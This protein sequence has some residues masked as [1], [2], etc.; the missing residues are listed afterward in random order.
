MQN[1]HQLVYSRRKT[2]KTWNLTFLTPYRR[3][4]TKNAI[5]AFNFYNFE[6]LFPFKSIFPLIFYFHPG[7]GRSGFNYKLFSNNRV[8][9]DNFSS[10]VNIFRDFLLIIFSRFSSV[11]L[12]YLLPIK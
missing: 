8:L 2:K 4:N 6:L 11:F 5:S 10:F 12:D 9:Y 3:I 7:L 1:F